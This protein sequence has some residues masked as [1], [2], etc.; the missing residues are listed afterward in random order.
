M[1]LCLFC[2]LP[3]L[4]GLPVSGTETDH[5]ELRSLLQQVREATGKR[6]INQLKPLLHD[7]FVMT[8]L[9]QE[10]VVGADGLRGLFDEWF[11]RSGAPLRSLTVDP[12]ATELS[13]IYEG[14]F[15]TSYGTS[16]D[17]FVLAD[18]TEARF[19]THWTASL[20]K[21]SGHWKLLTLHVGANP[22]DNP[23]INAYRQGMGLGGVA[24]EVMKLF[25]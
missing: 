2:C 9:T 15:A 18:G 16:Q 14:R 17:T 13:R 19:N 11:D 10:V 3:A 23:L 4:A 25:K 20:I 22:Q 21:Q 1:G 5:Q 12:T 7:D 6:D 8:A 24:V